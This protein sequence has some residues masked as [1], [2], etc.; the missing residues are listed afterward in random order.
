MCCFS[1]PTLPPGTAYVHLTV[2]RAQGV[3]ANLNRRCQ[4]FLKGIQAFHF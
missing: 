2:V 4:V 3:S 1:M